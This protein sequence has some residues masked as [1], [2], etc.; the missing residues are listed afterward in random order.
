MSDDLN[1]INEESSEPNEEKTIH[2]FDRMFFGNRKVPLHT[3]KKEVDKNEYSEIGQ[4]IPGLLDHPKLKNIDI[5]EVTKNVDH[6]LTSLDEFKPI[7]QK[8]SPFI[9]KFFQKGK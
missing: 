2:P 5:D 3:E 8:V 7:F 6:L 9:S 4:L 1:R